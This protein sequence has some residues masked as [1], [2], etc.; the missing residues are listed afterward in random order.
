MKINQDNAISAGTNVTINGGMLD[1]NGKTDTIGSLLLKS[2]SVINGTLYANSYIIESGTATANIVGPGGLQKTTSAQATAGA[3]SAPNV[4]IAAGQLTATSINTGTLTLSAGTTLTIAAIPGGPSASGGLTPLAARALQAVPTESVS[5]SAITEAAV[6]SSS[7]VES[8]VIAE[9]QSVMQSAVAEV[10]VQSSSVIEDA[11]EEAAIAT[12]TVS[13]MP[14]TESFAQ[15]KPVDTAVNHLSIQSPTDSKTDSPALSV[16][17]ESWSQGALAG[18]QA[19]ETRSTAF[20][21]SRDE[22][23]FA[24]GMTGK[25][26]SASAINKWL[27]HSAALQTIVS[28]PNRSGA[29]AEGVLDVARHARAGKHASQLENALDRVLAEEEDTFLLIQ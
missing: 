23:P 1:L 3:V 19:G 26:A 7:T 8:A 28:S 17:V 11:T 16:I 18:K 12:S 25:R 22:P 21:S 10:V 9:S 6:Q 2:G 29:D 27:V 5:Q 4:T 20:T 14:L 24:A 15:S 13:A